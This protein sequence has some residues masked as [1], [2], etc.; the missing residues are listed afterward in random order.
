LFTEELASKGIFLPTFV[1]VSE[2]NK[3]RAREREREN[4]WHEYINS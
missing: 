2:R 4:L 3:E 1:C